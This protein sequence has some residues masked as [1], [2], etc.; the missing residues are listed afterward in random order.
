MWPDSVRGGVLRSHLQFTPVFLL[1]TK[2]VLL[3]MGLGSCML[4]QQRVNFHHV[5]LQL[6]DVLLVVLYIF[7]LPFVL[8]CGG[9][10]QGQ[11]NSISDSAFRDTNVNQPLTTIFLWPSTVDLM[12]RSWMVSVSSPARFA[13]LTRSFCARSQ[14][15]C[16][17]VFSLSFSC[18]NLVRLWI[19]A[20]S[21]PTDSS[22]DSGSGIHE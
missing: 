15:C 19:V 6:P 9:V 12:R 16:S 4:A 10:A 11:V 20:S 21:G 7:F 13:M 17:C 5:V 2:V 1:Q 18:S 22:L 8:T 14:N 3:Q